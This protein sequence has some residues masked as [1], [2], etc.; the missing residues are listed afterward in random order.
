MSS[1]TAVSAGVGEQATEA[2]ASATFDE[3]IED[4]KKVKGRLSSHLKQFYERKTVGS[5]KRQAT[6]GAVQESGSHLANMVYGQVGN[7]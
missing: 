5:E 1:L 4:P 7:H 2:A 3:T 6:A